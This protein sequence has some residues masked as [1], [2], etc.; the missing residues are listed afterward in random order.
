MTKTQETTL[1]ETPVCTVVEKKFKE[2]KFKPIGIKCP[3]WVMVIP[4]ERTSD[5]TLVIEQTRWGVEHKTIEWPAGTCED[6]ELPRTTARREFEEETGI[7]LHANDIEYLG[8]FVPNPALFDNLMHVFA[9]YS[10][11]LEEDLKK[12]GKQRLDENEDCEVKIVNLSDQE[13]H[14]DGQVGLLDNAMSL[15]AWK[16]LDV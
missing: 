11:N 1:L 14:V 3:D 13:K 10:E 4:L 2:T 7:K 6:E 8:S 16:L 9:Y 5:K 12:A 15:A